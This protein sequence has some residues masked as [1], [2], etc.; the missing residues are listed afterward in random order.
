[1]DRTSLVSTTGKSVL[2]I[3]NIIRL[4]LLVPSTNFVICEVIEYRNGFN[5]LKNA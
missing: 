2:L 3:P 5:I 1:M 4:F